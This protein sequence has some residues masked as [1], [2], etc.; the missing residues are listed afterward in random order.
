MFTNTHA[1]LARE[2][3]KKQ[4][5]PRG[6]TDAAV[7]E[8][9]VRVPRHE[10]LDLLPGREAEAYTDKAMPIGSGQ[11]ISQPFMVGMMTQLLQ[12]EPG[13]RVL[14]I[15]TGSG[16]QAAILLELGVTLWSIE[17]SQ[18]LAS[19][20]GESRLARQAPTDMLHLA[21]GD[22]TLGWPEGAPYDRIIVTAGAP[23]LP[24]EYDRQLREGGLI[25]I[26]IGSR[27]EQKLTVFEKK[28][29]TLH[30]H[31]HFACKFVPLM[32]QDGWK[33]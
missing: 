4:L 10:F 26:P 23:D 27:V 7:L 22:G 31:E 30:R 3:V 29:F 25:V 1:S 6:V 8:A 2:M 14:E 18:S 24:A 20:A 33:D 13:M 28:D 15:G 32:G 17:Q 12:V 11:T 16:Y 21:W 5:Q 19:A 9:M